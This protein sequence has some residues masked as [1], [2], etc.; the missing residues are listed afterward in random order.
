MTPEELEIESKHLMAVIPGVVLGDLLNHIKELKSDLSKAQA[1]GWVHPEEVK[2]SLERT[3][4]KSDKSIELL[5]KLF[6]IQSEIVLNT[7]S[8]QI[9]KQFQ[10]NLLSHQIASF[11]FENGIISPKDY[12]DYTKQFNSLDRGLGYPDGDS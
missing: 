4:N 9:R 1:E 6:E 2:M 7:G 12:Q 8:E 5:K 11:L 10:I 3:K